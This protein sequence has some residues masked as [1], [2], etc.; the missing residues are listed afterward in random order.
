MNKAS[1]GDEIP[2][3]L[4][5]VLKMMLLK[6]FIQF[7]H[8]VISDSVTPWTAAC[9]AFLSITNS[10]SLLK[11]MSIESVMQS[12]HLILSSPSPPALTLSQHQVL[13]K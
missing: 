5:Q 8:S 6:C 4:F 12:S 7:S 9:K 3:E 10:Q 11:F 2:A 1:G 13:F